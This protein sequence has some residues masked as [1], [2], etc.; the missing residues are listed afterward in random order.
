LN[1]GIYSAVSA[2]LAALDRLDVATSNLA[3]ANTIG[4]KGELAIQNGSYLRGTD[5]HRGA[6]AKSSVVTDFS[7][8]TIEK[9]GS[10][11]NVAIRGEGFFVV[12]TA[13]GERLTRRGTFELD[14]EGYLVTSDGDRVQGAS[15]DLNL[16]TIRPD[17]I[18]IGADGQIRAGQEDLGKLRIVAVDDPSQLVRDQGAA[19]VAA[20]AAVRDAARTDFQIQQGAVERSNVSPIEGLVSLIETMRA[21]EAYTRASQQHDTVTQRAVGDVGKF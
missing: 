1:T 11:L 21:F 16:G 10:P 12:D 6:I 9:T 7:Q 3:N 14:A 17:P 19:F 4:F 2:S 20:P 8:G 5:V 15:G 18:T 13:R